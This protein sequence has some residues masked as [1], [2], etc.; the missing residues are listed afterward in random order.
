M[1][2]KSIALILTFTAVM[3]GISTFPALGADGW[4]QDSAQEWQYMENNKKLVNCWLAWTDGTLRYVGGDGRIMKDSWVNIHDKR[5]RVGA[6]GTR[7]ENTWFSVLSIPKQPSIKPSNSWYYAGADGSVLR[8]GWYAVDGKYYYF[9]EWGN[10]PRKMF[11]NLDD[12]RYYVDEEGARKTP[13]WFSLTSVDGKGNSNTNWYYV[14]EDGSL[15]KNGW[16]PMDGKMCYFDTYGIFYRNRWFN[17][18][19][20][21]YY[22]DEDGARQDGWFSITVTGGDGQEKTNWYYAEPNGVI[23]RNGW[24]EKDGK[25]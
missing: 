23:W 21:R 7:Y 25:W 12:K 22:V 3:M 6:D 17:L 10:S 2:G 8:N 4:Q 16:Y 24:R 15:L 11:F 5:Y 13:G 14:T 18:E 1:K 19:N 20:D 9:Y